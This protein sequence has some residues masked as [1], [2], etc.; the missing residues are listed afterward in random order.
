[1]QDNFQ[2]SESLATEEAEMDTLLTQYR[3]KHRLLKEGKISATKTNKNAH[4]RLRDRPA[5]PS[6]ESLVAVRTLRV[7]PQPEVVLL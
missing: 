7:V 4:A 5:L 6:A 1:M 3:T 2:T